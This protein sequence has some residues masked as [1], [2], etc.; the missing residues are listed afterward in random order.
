MEERISIAKH[1]HE[2]RDRLCGVGRSTTR[3]AAHARR[4][5]K[6]LGMREM[7]KEQP[8]ALPAA[9]QGPRARLF[10][11]SSALARS[12]KR[13]PANLTV[14]KRNF[15]SLT[16]PRTIWGQFIFRLIKGP[17]NERTLISRGM[18]QG[19]RFLF[20]LD[21]TIGGSARDT[22]GGLER[23]RFATPT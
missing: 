16:L 8:T 15:R 18:N 17:K 11:Q 14:N 12:R 13:E 3:R 23:I 22:V 20:H 10:A 2:G 6:L 9:W 19:G 5:S 7:S 4:W 21:L 1:F